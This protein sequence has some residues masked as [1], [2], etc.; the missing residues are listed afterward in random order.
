VLDWAI[1]CPGRPAASIPTALPNLPQRDFEASLGGI[2]DLLTDLPIVLAGADPDGRLT[3]LT[4]A[5]EL[6]TGWRVDESL[7]RRLLDFI[8]GDDRE[9]CADVEEQLRRGASNRGECLVRISHRAGAY[10][11]VE[12]RWFAL[13]APDGRLRGFGGSLLDVTRDTDAESPARS[14]IGVSALHR[15]EERSRALFEGAAFGIFRCTSIGRFVDVNPALGAMLGYADSSA[16]IGRSLVTDL[17]AEDGE[18]LLLE[19]DFA[20]NRVNDWYDLQWRRA[21]GS[22]IQVRL[23]VS[24]ERDA[25]GRIEFIQGIAENVTERK[26]REE[27]VRRAERMSSL[28]RTLAG[29][30]HEINNPLAAI[31]GFA[32][33]LLKRDQS[34]DDRH[35]HETILQAARRAARIV[36]DLL[37]VAR[38]EE[39]VERSRMDLNDIVAY[40]VDTQR[41]ATETRG[42]HATLDLSP[43]RADVVADGAQLEQVVLNLVVNARQALEKLMERRGGTDLEW[44]PSIHITTRVADEQVTL[45]VEDNGP[46]IPVVD[47][48]HIF[49]PF[50]TTRDEGEG[51]G[52]GLSVVHGIVTS[53]GGTI[54]VVSAIGEGTRFTVRLPLAPKPDDVVSTAS[55]SAT[56]EEEP[57]RGVRPLDI[58]VVDD[59]AV[60]RE[61]LQ[62]FLASRGHAVVTA[63]DGIQALR[64]AEG[65]RFDVVV[66]DLRMPSMDG[67]EVI[68]RLRELPTCASTRFVLSTGDTEMSDST[69]DLGSSDVQVV[70]KPYDVDALVRVVED[71]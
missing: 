5:W 65:S 17:C 21:D 57:E 37:T 70:H 39:S 22:A 45:E 44:A 13:R 58:L 31:T 53:H 1:P 28:G 19:R 49:D 25:R 43:D 24:V 6:V 10:R 63:A 14:L 50:W 2:G 67:R 32:Q 8:A 48:P 46:G 35:A 56:R 71:G 55:E 62:R 60:I 52:L 54:D 64:L 26:R 20:A 40:I 7:G 68:R 11:D 9:K 33:I 29:V 66:S 47:L 12:I 30:A 69:V 42:V 38:R 59:E 41:Y 27:I 34:S 61:L 36:K 3:T 51:S 16:M 18:R 4:P 15:A 23:A